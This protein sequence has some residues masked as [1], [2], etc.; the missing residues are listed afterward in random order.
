MK[1]YLCLRI[2]YEKHPISLFLTLYRIP[3]EKKSIDYNKKNH[4]SLA[5]QI[6]E[7]K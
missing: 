3:A 7:D 5:I 2:P 4:Y 6:P 1:E